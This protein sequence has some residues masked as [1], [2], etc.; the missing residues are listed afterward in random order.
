MNSPRRKT[1]VTLTQDEARS[2][3][4]VENEI[5]AIQIQEVAEGT[6]KTCHL[7]YDFAR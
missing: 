7:M 4:I 2:A 3:D 5:F 6:I 1:W